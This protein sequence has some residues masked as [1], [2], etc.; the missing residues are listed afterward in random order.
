[1]KEFKAEIE[2]QELHMHIYTVCAT[3]TAA[4]YCCAE[5]KKTNNAFLLK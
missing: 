2:Y 4:K 1:M 3:S 5:I